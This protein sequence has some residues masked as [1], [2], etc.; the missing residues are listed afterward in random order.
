MKKE[1]LCVFV[2][3]LASMCLSDPGSDSTTDAAPGVA[4]PGGDVIYVV[5]F[6]RVQQC[7]C[8]INVGKW[9]EETLQSHFPDEY[10]EGT[11]VYMDVCV[12]DDP[13]LATHYNAYGASLFVNVVRGGSENIMQVTEVWGL[14]HNHDAYIEFF[15]QYIENLLK[16]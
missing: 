2:C 8:C 13:E 3:V 14:C 1:L 15:K 9:A 7:T 5:H 16:G 10:K 12:E 6:H 4:S 11:L